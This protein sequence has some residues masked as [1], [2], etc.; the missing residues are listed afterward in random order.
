MGHVGVA[1]LLMIAAGAAALVALGVWLISLREL[2]GQMPGDAVYYAAMADGPMDA[3]PAPFRFRLLVPA[4]AAALPLATE[5]AL[6]AITYGS[7]WLTY[8]VGMVLCL[9][10]GLPLGATAAA[11]VM[12]FSASANLYAFSNPYLTDAFGTM[13]KTVAV[14]ALAAGWLGLFAVAVVL[15][16]LARETAIVLAPAW[17]VVSPRQTVAVVVVAV[18]ALVAPRVLIAGDYLN[19]YMLPSGALEWVKL[20]AVSWGP[21]WVFAAVGLV[22]FR[23]RWAWAAA[24][25]LALGAV[26]SSLVAYD[27]NRMMG[28]LFPV[29]LLGTAQTVANG[30]QRHRVLTATTAAV[31]VVNALFFNANRFGGL[32]E[33][34]TVVA[35]GLGLLLT[36]TLGWQLLTARPAAHSPQSVR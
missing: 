11:T 24:G 6:K 12:T 32:V 33:G 2:A 10:V 20:A 15:G 19:S 8:V 18:A 35:V 17:W 22:L 3:V 26:A 1:R 23:Q 31:V 16:V 34:G 28:I 36:V 27:T 9:R 14:Y 30:W 25:V 29:V 13:T 7:L 4:L 5:V 21:L